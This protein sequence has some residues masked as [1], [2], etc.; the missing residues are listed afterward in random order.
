MLALIKKAASILLVVCFVL[1]LSTC[2]HKPEADGKV[3]TESHLY[4]YE[5]AIMDLDEVR[6]GKY[7]T[8]FGVLMAISVFFVPV[9]SL[10]FHERLQSL[11]VFAASFLSAYFLLIWVFVFSTKVEVGG[12][13]AV[14]CWAVLFAESATT[15]TRLARNRALF[16][17]EPVV[18]I[19]AFAGG[20]GVGWFLAVGTCLLA[21]R[22]DLSLRP[23]QE[24]D[25]IVALSLGGGIAAAIWAACLRPAKLA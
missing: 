5:M 12:W 21:G 19:V 22:L 18:W 14:L 7:D 23:V 24:K 8:L 11:I 3:A 20:A 25:W 13:L 10:A 15:V 9:I 6:A 4:G 17:H 16:K 2:T 1:P